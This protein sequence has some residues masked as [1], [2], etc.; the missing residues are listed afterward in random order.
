ML[1]TKKIIAFIL[2]VILLIPLF[3]CSSAESTV[4]ESASVP[5]NSK[6]S[7]PIFDTEPP[8][9]SD[10]NALPKLNGENDDYYLSFSFQG[11]IA[12]RRTYNTDNYAFIDENGG[13]FTDYSVK[14]NEYYYITNGKP[15]AYN[16]GKYIYRIS[17]I[18]EPV[19][20]YSSSSNLL[21]ISVWDDI[22]YFTENDIL[23]SVDANGEN[24]TTYGNI[25]KITALECHNKNTVTWVKLHLPNG[26][27]LTKSALSTMSDP[28]DYTVEYGILDNGEIRPSNINEYMEVFNPKAFTGKRYEWDYIK[29]TNTYTMFDSYTGI[30][31]EVFYGEVY[32]SNFNIDNL[33][34]LFISNGVLYSYYPYSTPEIIFEN[35]VTSVCYDK[36][37]IYFTAENALYIVNIEDN[38]IS[39]L[40]ELNEN[41]TFIQ[42]R[43]DEFTFTQI[44]K[45]GEV[46]NN[47]DFSLQEIADAEFNDFSID[48]IENGIIY[49]TKKGR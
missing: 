17:K 1:R 13:F 38:S 41:V 45:N 29:E 9:V 43:L 22:I 2:C 14:N 4:I 15:D 5:E 35:G 31:Q 28:C 47:R 6:P 39:R 48:K 25:G 26:E 18:T 27:L 44:L 49:L 10:Y 12:T 34:N 40:G 32:N 42:K 30:S 37:N 36:R 8:T 21:N 16:G 24:K 3:G 7:A 46:I 19:L 33:Q 20:L 23:C 11:N